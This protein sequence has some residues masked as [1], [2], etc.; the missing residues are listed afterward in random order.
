MLWNTGLHIIAGLFG[1]NIFSWTS[2][3]IIACLVITSLIQGIDMTRLYRTTVKRINEQPDHIRDEQMQTFKKRL[4][5]TFPQLFIMK[6]IGYG[7]VTM[8]SA[9]IMRAI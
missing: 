2:Q 5:I 6:V 3:G 8:A 7:L 4:P 1:S 9:S